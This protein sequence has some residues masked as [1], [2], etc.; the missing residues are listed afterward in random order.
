[1][2]WPETLNWWTGEYEKSQ[3]ALAAE[4]EISDAALRAAKSA[5]GRY[6]EALDCLTA[7]RELADKLADAL[8]DVASKYYPTA[9]GMT[10][11]K[12]RKIL[13]TYDA[14]RSGK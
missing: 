7:E 2:T 10:R 1:M 13:D 4:R 14:L 5:R 12:A 8:R 9:A 11:S 6:R 3:A